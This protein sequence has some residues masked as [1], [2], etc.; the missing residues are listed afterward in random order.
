MSHGWFVLL[1]AL[2]V[3]VVVAFFAF[4]TYAMVDSVG[5][6]RTLGIWAGS[7]AFAAALLF[8]VS[9]ITGDPLWQ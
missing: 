9:A 7:I 6:W 5:G 3:I 8:I 1:M 4:I 2:A